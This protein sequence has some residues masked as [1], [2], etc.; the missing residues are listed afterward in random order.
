MNKP[1][2]RCLYCSRRLSDPPECDGPRTSAM[3][4][5]RWREYMRDVKEISGLTFDD[6]AGNSGRQLS[7]NTVKTVLAPSAKGDIQRETA[8]LIENALFGSSN[9]HPCPVDIM[10]AIPDEQKRVAELEAVL[11]QLR[12]N[13]G[14]T[15]DFQEKELAAVRADAEA[16]IKEIKDKHAREIAHLQDQIRYLRSINDRNGRI[17]DNLMGK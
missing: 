7:A 13:I 2:N 4:I 3:A 14:R 1:Y 12:A 10:D 9:A 6:I 16:R 15:H 17:I 5:D 8:R 11:A